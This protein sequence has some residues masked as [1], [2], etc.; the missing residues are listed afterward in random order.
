MVEANYDEDV[1]LDNAVQ[2]K[3]SSSASSNH[4]SINQSIEMIKRHDTVDLQDIILLHL[5]DGNS[6]A[7]KFQRMVKAETGHDCYIADKG[8]VVELKDRE[9]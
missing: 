6:D 8:L 3:W 7:K 5:S 9:F 1:I 2:D 4:L